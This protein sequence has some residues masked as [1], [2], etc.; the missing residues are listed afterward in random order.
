MG[1]SEV[2]DIISCIFLI[3]TYVDHRN[4]KDE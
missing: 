1:V 4:K 3:L 2:V